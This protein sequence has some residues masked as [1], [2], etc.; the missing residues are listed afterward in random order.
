MDRPSLVIGGDMETA[1]DSEATPVLKTD[2]CIAYRLLMV[3]VPFLDCFL[4]ISLFPGV[5]SVNKKVLL[6]PS[7]IL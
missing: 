1:K 3:Q 6:R 7:D 5:T 4:I 2:A